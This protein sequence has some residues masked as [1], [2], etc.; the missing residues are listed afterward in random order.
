MSKR[1]AIT[2]ILR[3]SPTVFV[4]PLDQRSNREASL[5][6]F[7]RRV[8]GYAACRGVPFIRQPYE[9]ERQSRPGLQHRCWQL[10]CARMINQA[11]RASWACHHH[12]SHP[13]ETDRPRGKNGSD[14]QR[15]LQPLILYRFPPRIKRD[16]Y[17][18]FTTFPMK[19]IAPLRVSRIMNING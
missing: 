2:D 18:G 16:I 8:T 6:F 4:S 5:L 10:M 3:A 17:A 14:Y 15:T 1:A 11:N 9:P 19:R 12:R 7:S 13:V